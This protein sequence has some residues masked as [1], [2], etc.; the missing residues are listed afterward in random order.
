MTGFCGLLN[1]GLPFVQGG[2]QNICN[3]IP[4]DSTINC[5]FD[6]DCQSGI[7]SDG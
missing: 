2:Y 6:L 3:Y 5:L 1:T 4:T 7:C